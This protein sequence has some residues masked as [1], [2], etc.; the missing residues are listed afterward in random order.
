MLKFRQIFR[1]GDVTL[2][3]MV[4]PWKIPEMRAA[5]A[6]SFHALL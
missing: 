5:R 6:T 2:F 4:R 3:C 1:F